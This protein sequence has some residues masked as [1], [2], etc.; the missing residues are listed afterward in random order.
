[1]VLA[2]LRQR[3]EPVGALERTVGELLRRELVVGLRLLLEALPDV[4]PPGSLVTAR[5]IV[6][7]RGRAFGQLEVLGARRR[8]QR[9]AC[10][11]P[12]H[13]QQ[14]SEFHDWPPKEWRRAL[15]PALGLRAERE[16]VRVAVVDPGGLTRR[17][18]RVLAENA[19]ALCRVVPRG[20]RQ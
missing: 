1:V 20:V 3:L 4:G 18:T 8:R 15:P 13:R 17:R 6:V 7:Q 11:E 2:R 14:S 19:V 12:D 10:Q 5:A 9:P 16:T